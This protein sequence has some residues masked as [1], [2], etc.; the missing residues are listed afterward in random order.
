MCTLL[1]LLL[2]FCGLS[3]VFVVPI[4]SSTIPPGVACFHISFF[5]KEL[6]FNLAADFNLLS[7]NTLL[8]GQTTVYFFQNNVIQFMRGYGGE[9]I[10]IDFLI[11]AHGK[12]SRSD[13]SLPL[14]PG[15][16]LGH[17][18]C[19]VKP[20]L[21]LCGYECSNPEDVLSQFPS[22]VQ[23]NDKYSLLIEFPRKFFIPHRS[24]SKITQI[25][26]LPFQ[27]R[28]FH[29]NL[30]FI[31][32]FSQ[33]PESLHFSCLFTSSCYA[34][35]RS[36]HAHKLFVLRTVPTTEPIWLDWLEYLPDWT[37]RP[38]NSSD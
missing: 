3:G 23:G 34:L 10:V 5:L 25:D 22:S 15:C 19:R 29:C 18:S 32:I 4:V 27:L 21:R 17:A 20:S 33:R 28:L 35:F 6:K 2:T 37:V 13:W 36:L 14:F 1:S 8:L 26:L 31:V 30:C 38:Y 12:W 7:G 11:C 16:G 24:A 9:S